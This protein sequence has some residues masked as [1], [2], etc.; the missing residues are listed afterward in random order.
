MLAHSASRD[1]VAIIDI[2]SN[3]VRLVIYDG[4]NRAP[5][6]IHNERNICSL[7]ATLT[8]TGYLN[9]DGVTQA[10]DSIRRFSGLLQALKIKNASAVA[11][12]AVRDAH[13]G[14][15]FIDTIRNEFGLTVLVIDGEEEARLSAL[16]VLGNGMGHDGIIGDYGGGSLELIT[17]SGEKV[18]NRVSLKIGSHRLHAEKNR[19]AR[20]KLIEDQLD[21]VEFLKEY[22]GCNFYALG[23]SWRTMAKAHMHMK[24]HPLFVLDHYAM[25]GKRA[26][27]FAD[28]ISRQS[29]KSLERA[30]GLSSK[31][32][33]DMS[34]AALA[35]ERLFA[36]LKPKELVF[37]ATGL[38]E[39]LI[40]DRLAPAQ[41]KI[42]PLVAS[43]LK[44]AE[45]TSRFDDAKAFQYLFKWVLPLFPDRSE[46]EERLI[47]AS[48]LLSDAGWFEHEDYQADHTFRRLLVM[49]YFA[50]DHTGRALL[51]LAGYIRY[52][53]YLRQ[54]SRAKQRQETTWPALKILNETEIKAAIVLGQ[55]QR[56]AY[57]L[58]GGALM[59]LKDADLLM[60]EK[61]VTLRLSE[62]TQ[63]LRG[64]IIEGALSDMAAVLG[65]K[66][67][68]EKL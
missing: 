20:I 48:C 66:A 38:R 40:F 26:Q 12:A 22:K 10:L 52:R 57:L 36:R 58:T 16:G 35:M 41:K 13:D 18:T 31:R 46:M 7:G 65:R 43:C 24:E 6:K 50:V 54:S 59:L 1:Y 39:G 68:I 4:L 63:H 62:K 3:A 53:G 2:G 64:D 17:V 5:V 56:I 14:Q 37:S 11:T 42:D 45:K 8:K 30:A 61:T 55:A 27:D 25:S 28:L 15:D 44:V 23:G 19:A 47:E 29:P 51:A 49:P 34:V 33:K 60:D 32:V 21:T 67:V 9:P